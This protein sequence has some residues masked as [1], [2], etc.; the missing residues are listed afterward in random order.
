MAKFE[1]CTFHTVTL[2]PGEQ[3]NLPPGA[4]VISITDSG[5]ITSN[6]CA[7]LDNIETPVCYGF[8]IASHDDTD[9][10]TQVWVGDGSNP[11]IFYI[12]VYLGDIYYPFTASAGYDGTAIITQLEALSFGSIMTGF[13]TSTSNDGTA[14]SKKSYII[15]NTIPSIGDNLKLYGYTA[16]PNN[17]GG[18]GFGAVYFDHPCLLRSEIIDLNHRD[19]CDCPSLT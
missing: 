13:C 11:N 10:D 16:G 18:T 4:E 12:G 5:A 17:G 8:V 1:T 3:F 19:V 15:F 6:G 2:L 7:N 14:D 9:S